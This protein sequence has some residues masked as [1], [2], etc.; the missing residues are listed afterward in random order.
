MGG[1]G[2][3]GAD[4]PFMG[5]GPPPIPSTLGSPDPHDI[6]EPAITCQIGLKQNSS[7]WSIEYQ[8]MIGAHDQENKGNKFANNSLIAV[9]LVATI[10]T[11]G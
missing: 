10:S 11:L 6:E 2:L 3:D 1:T 7:S 5:Y 9:R 8:L 4:S